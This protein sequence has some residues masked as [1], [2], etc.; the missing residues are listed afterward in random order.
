MIEDFYSL[1]KDPED[2]ILFIVGDGN[3]SLAT[4]KTHWETL[5]PSLSSEDLKKTIQQDMH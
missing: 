3:H 2:P 1:I 4:A 5:K